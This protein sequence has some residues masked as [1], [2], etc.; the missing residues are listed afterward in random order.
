MEN[1]V[2]SRNV[3]LN[4]LWAN[5]ETSLGGR[6]NRP[7]DG[8][9]I[10]LCAVCGKPLTRPHSYGGRT[11]CD[12]HISAFYEDLPEF[13]RVTAITFGIGI[14]VVTVL[15]L[16]NIIAPP[17]IGTTA[18][19]VTGIGVC[20]VIPATWILLWYRLQS[21]KNTELS[22]FFLVVIIIG[23]L[24][25]AAV[26]HP[27]SL[28]VFGLEQWFSRTSPTNRFV[29]SILLNGFFH[30]FVIYGMVRY[31]AWFHPSFT[32]RSYGVVL[33]LAACWG[34]ATTLNIFY[35]IDHGGLNL[36]SGSL[37]LLSQLCA[38]VA[39]SIILGYFL[40]MNRFEDLPPYFLAV[41]LAVSACLNG[42]L[43]YAG[44]ELNYVGLSLTQNGFSP[45]PGALVNLLSV[46]AS[47][48]IVSGL[49]RRQNAL[50][51]ARVEMGI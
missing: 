6:Y 48:I 33:T 20:C 51:R 3:Q 36:L 18:R 1:V 28:S 13:W 9:I 5:I 41:G 34:Y 25:A 23:V 8:K 37:R 19:I 47:S 21:S 17:N 35:V 10:Y 22:S 31:F 15:A 29:G 46:L 40:G 14:V 7:M 4:I 50:T 43:L 32:N 30:L 27:L 39:P 42:L 38:F 24:F 26:T 11:F 49:L 16:S 2:V 45:W 44:S 12:F